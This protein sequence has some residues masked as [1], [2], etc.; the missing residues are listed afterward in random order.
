M[1]K[2]TKTQIKSILKQQHDAIK[3][4]VFLT[5]SKTHLMGYKCWI[6]PIEMYLGNDLEEFEKIVNEF[7]NDYC[8]SEV[9]KTVHFYLKTN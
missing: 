2:V 5:S 7:R 9:G 3:I 4:Q 1:I 8:N 6:E